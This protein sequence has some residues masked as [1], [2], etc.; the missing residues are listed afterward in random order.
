VLIGIV[1]IAEGVGTHIS[2]GYV[3]VAMAFALGV[4]V[5]N[6]RLRKGR[7]RRGART[8]RA[9]ALRQSVV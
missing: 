1:L 8:R 2:R 6:M 7:A 5:L 9:G 4:E 3:Y